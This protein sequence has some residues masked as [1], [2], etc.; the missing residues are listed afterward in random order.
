MQIV[1]PEEYRHL[2]V[3]DESRPI[4]KI[5]HATLRQKAVEV[6]KIT[7]RTDL[8]IN[9]LMRI[10][11]RA[12]GIGL[13]APQVGILQRIVVIAPDDM[14]PMALVNPKIIKSEGKQIG[15]EG[16]L[17]IPGLYGDVERAAYVEVETLDRKGREIILELEGMPARV[18]Q[19][20]IDHLEGVLFVDKV[21]PETLHWMSPDGDPGE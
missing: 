9:D 8:L 14:R 6:P 19:H 15:Q 21:I 16:C 2:Y 20:E 4:L 10:M 3:T 1:V 7:K 18:V 5:P 13:A 12:N 11:R 17:S